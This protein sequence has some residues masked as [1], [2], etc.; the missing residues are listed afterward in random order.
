[1]QERN[2]YIN[3]MKAK[4]D[5]LDAKIHKWQAKADGL[6]A[7]AKIEY[8]KKVSHLRQERD[9]AEAY[10]NKVKSAS[11]DS[12]KSIKEG[13]ESAYEKMKTALS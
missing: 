7:D 8:I 5:E 12:W 10:L 2:E 9:D 6:S 3:K 11:D 13:F 1:M 4:L